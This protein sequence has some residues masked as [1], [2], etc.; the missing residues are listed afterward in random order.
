MKNLHS[1]CSSYT[2][3]KNRRFISFI[4]SLLLVLLSFLGSAPVFAAKESS[5]AEAAPAKQEVI[6]AFLDES[7]AVKQPLIVVNRYRLDEAQ[8]ICDYGAYEEVK[9]L[10]GESELTQEGDKITALA[11][12]GEWYYQASLREELPWNFH[13]RMMLDGQERS[14]EEL[15]GAQGKLELELSIE[16]NPQAKGKLADQFMLLVN[17]TL[18]NQRVTNLS[19]PGFI[20]SAAGVNTM[21]TALA[22]PG[23]KNIFRF[24]AEV[25]DF[26][27]SRPQI[28]AMPM[29]LDLSEMNLP[30]DKMF[31]MVL[32]P[33]ENPQETKTFDSQKTA[34]LYGQFL[35][36]SSEVLGQDLSKIAPLLQQMKDIKLPGTLELKMFSRNLDQSKLD[37]EDKA[38]NEAMDRLAKMAENLPA[39][40]AESMKKD[41][42]LLRNAY[43]SKMMIVNQTAGKFRELAPSISA[44]A[45]LDETDLA[46]L[47][48]TLAKV[49]QLQGLLSE[50]KT[51]FRRSI[52][53]LKTLMAAIRDDQLGDYLNALT[54]A[55]KAQSFV[56]EKNKNVSSLQFTILAA[57]IPKKEKSVEKADGQSEENKADESKSF[58]ELLGDLFSPEAESQPAA[59]AEDTQ[60][61]SEKEKP[62]G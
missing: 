33:G 24:T 36:L 56:S 11:G 34:E 5:K 52:D 51:T 10:V 4:L 20:Q 38:A 25:N 28:V 57:E 31:G 17:L 59:P 35:D 1:F 7:G 12:P 32:A 44:A 19:A 6:Y 58:A 47:Q 27:M 2:Q 62:Q 26:A 39:G 8:E 29:S 13:F 21:L 45:N 18:D 22:F 30:V 48:E 46:K 42:D 3:R 15:S 9:R 50:N 60:E 37:A 53:S 40:Q 16:P 23:E 43:F 41:L 14:A 49:G 55:V 61:N 54:P